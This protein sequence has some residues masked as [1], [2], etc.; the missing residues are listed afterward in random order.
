MTRGKLLAS[1]ACTRAD[2]HKLK[3]R[4]LTRPGYHPVT[5]K[6]CANHTK[7]YLIHIRIIHFIFLSPVTCFQYFCN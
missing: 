4:I 7:T 2:C 6:I 3:A 1:L 5:Y